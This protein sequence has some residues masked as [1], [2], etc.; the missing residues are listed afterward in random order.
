LAGLLGWLLGSKSKS[1]NVGEPKNS[2]VVKL[3]EVDSASNPNLIAIDDPRYEAWSEKCRAF[4][5]QIGAIDSDVIAYIISPEFMGAPAWPTTRQSF[6]IVRTSASVIIASDGLTDLFVD[7]DVAN[8]GFGCEVYIETD[9]LIGADFDSIKASWAF[10]LIENFA[11]NVAD[12]GG[13]DSQLE[14]YGVI[15]TELPSPEAMLPTWVAKGDKLG[16]L[17]NVATPNRPARL[18]LDNSTVGMVPITLITPAEL[19]FVAKGGAEARTELAALLTKSG[20]H[21]LSPM[22]RVS[23]V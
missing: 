11:R 17:V 13:I 16:V 1:S 5:G 21:A 7:T 4:W 18:L 9:A 10:S 23:L 22:G 12:W 8:A 14:K 2:A 15:S 19:S 3:P 20:N 6:L